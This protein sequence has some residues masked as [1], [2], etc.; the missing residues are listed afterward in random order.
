VVDLGFFVLQSIGLVILLAWVLTHD[1]KEEG[2]PEAGLLAMRRQGSADTREDRETSR[3]RSA[4]HPR[5]RK[6]LRKAS[7]R[8]PEVRGP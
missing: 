4:A 8:Q 6:R 1:G 3:A 2:A 5:P 7:T